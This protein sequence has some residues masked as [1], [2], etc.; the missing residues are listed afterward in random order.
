MLHKWF[1]MNVDK[2]HQHHYLQYTDNALGCCGAWILTVWQVLDDMEEAQQQI[3]HLH[4][5]QLL[6][7]H[8]DL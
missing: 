3:L 6:V 7:L 1:R 8:Q 4:D 2:L 5:V